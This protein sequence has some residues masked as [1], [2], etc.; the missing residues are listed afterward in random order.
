MESANFPIL[1]SDSP[2][3]TDIENYGWPNP[4]FKINFIHVEGHELRKDD[5]IINMKELEALIHTALFLFKS[6]TIKSE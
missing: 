4:S 3:P 5:S 6:K 1:L 2:S